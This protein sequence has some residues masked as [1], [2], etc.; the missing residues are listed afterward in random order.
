[1]D[2]SCWSWSTNTATRSHG[3]VMN[4][5]NPHQGYG[6][7]KGTKPVTLTPTLLLPLSKPWGS[8][9]PLS[10]TTYQPDVSDL[11]KRCWGQWWF[12]REDHAVFVCKRSSPTRRYLDNP[13]SLFRFFFYFILFLIRQLIY[14]R[15]YIHVWSSQYIPTNSEE[16]HMDVGLIGI[17]LPCPGLGWPPIKEDGSMRTRKLVRS[18]CRPGMTWGWGISSCWR[19][20]ASRPN[21]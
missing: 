17:L 6:F 19:H 8:T 4:P 14:R 2:E 10:I 12:G 21:R 1:M 15:I 5:S 3:H 16:K 7:C 20:T 13:P 11:W 18:E 9:L